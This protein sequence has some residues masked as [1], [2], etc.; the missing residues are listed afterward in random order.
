MSDTLL[1]SYRYK[2]TL[3]AFVLFSSILVASWIAVYMP[4]F[5][6]V[7]SDVVWQTSDLATTWELLVGPVLQYAF[8]FGSFSFI[9]YGVLR[10]EKKGYTFLAVYAVA[11]ILWYFLQPLSYM[12][13]L[14]A[15]HWSEFLSSDVPVFLLSV[16]LDCLQI[17]CVVLVLF[18][19]ERK[20]KPVVTP[21][22]GRRAVQPAEWGMNDLL[23]RR[24]SFFV[25][26]VL[27]AIISPLI[28]IAQRLYLEGFYKMIGA[29][30]TFDAEGAMLLLGVALFFLSDFLMIPIGYVVV[31]FVHWLLLRKSVPLS[32]WQWLF[33]RVVP[34][35]KKSK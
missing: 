33:G 4:V 27:V 17:G 5:Y 11:D 24:K 7:T 9:I 18:L 25:G 34:T 31:R 29:G 6:W 13:I 20:N 15:I 16:F 19:L 3:G 2:R 23:R 14:G 1:E 12:W 22:R 21:P 32:F 28:M 26:A 10:F 35:E 30:L 8:Y